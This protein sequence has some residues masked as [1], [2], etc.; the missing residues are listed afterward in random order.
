MP[1]TGFRLAALA[2]PVAVFALVGCGSSD[3]KPYGKGGYGVN[4]PLE[5]VAAGFHE[6]PEANRQVATDKLPLTFID[7][8]GTPVDLA[9]FRGKSNVVLVVTKGL[10]QFPGGVYC[11]GCLAQMHALT[12]NLDDFKKR[13]AEVLVVFPGPSEKIGEFVTQAKAGGPDGKP[14]PVPLLL[15]KDLT[16][17]KQLDILADWAKPATYIL[18]KKGNVVYA[19]VGAGTTDRPSVKALLAQLDKANGAN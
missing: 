3:P 6:N 7:V 11:P 10:P 8:T 13:D 18:D 4:P 19:F 2:L 12:A 15:D 16:A 17:V 14:G 1:R 5:E 9:Q